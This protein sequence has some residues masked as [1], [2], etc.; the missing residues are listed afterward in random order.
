[1]RVSTSYL[2]FYVPRCLVEIEGR[3]D[4]SASFKWWPLSILECEALEVI[5]D[6]KVQQCD[7]RPLVPSAEDI[8]GHCA[9]P[10]RR[11]ESIPAPCDYSNR[12]FGVLLVATTEASTPLM[13]DLF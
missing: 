7:S 12:D 6:R 10:Q 9:G 13:L 4:E 3:R 2:Y 1:M 5:K 8:N 11:H